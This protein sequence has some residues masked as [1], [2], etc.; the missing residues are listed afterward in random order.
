[1]K[2]IELSRQRAVLQ[3]NLG[4]VYAG[5]AEWDRAFAALEESCEQREG[6][7]VFL[8]PFAAAIPGLSDD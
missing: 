7:L 4:V 1:L 3:L 2:A 5:L 8:K 6:V